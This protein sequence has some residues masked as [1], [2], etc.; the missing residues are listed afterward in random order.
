METPG[1]SGAPGRASDLLSA[2]ADGL[3]RETWDIHCLLD[4]KTGGRRKAG[5]RRVVERRVVDGGRERHRCEAFESIRLVRFGN[6][7]EIRLTAW[8]IETPDGRPVRFAYEVDM[9]PTTQAVR[10]EITAGRLRCEL[11]TGGRTTSTTRPWPADAGGFLAVEQ[12]LRRQPMQPGERRTVECLQAIPILGDLATAPLVAK[13]ELAAEAWEDVLLPSG[14]RR[15]LRIRSATILPAASAIHTTLW[16]DPQGETIKGALDALGQ[17]T[18][19]VTR[20]TA[21]RE[22]P[23]VDFD[24]G[25]DILVHLDRHVPNAHATS[26][27]KYRV[28]LRGGDPTGAFASC[29]SQQ[30]RRVSDHTAQI[31]VRRV[32]PDEPPEVSVAADTEPE[33]LQPNAMIQSDDPQVVAMAGAVAGGETDPWKVAVA[34]ERHVHDSLTTVDFSQVFADA[35]HVA[36]SRQGD[37]TEYAVLLAALC[38]ARGIPARVAFGLVYFEQ[39]HGLLYHMWNEV[40]VKDRWIPLDAT[41]GAGGIGAG[42]LKCVDSSLRG[43]SA[44]TGLL[45]IAD[46]VGRL[47]VDVLT[48]E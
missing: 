22:D 33:D 12:S 1:R 24:L 31:T 4:P 45:P 10:G 17:E 46:V 36:R 20:Q 9:P 48:V 42:H 21:L 19:R 7:T 27:V 38:R 35:A 25:W 30:V 41:L 2:P 14:R 47:H 39:R 23:A 8:S 28:T 13:V 29:L 15:L 18:F 6:T 3:P 11:L 34:L 43:A 40:W 26:R 37:C 5:H 16:T 44:Y 32:R